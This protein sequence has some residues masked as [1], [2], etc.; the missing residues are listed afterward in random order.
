[1]NFHPRQVGGILCL[2]S[3]TI[4][5]SLLYSCAAKA[6][7]VE[8]AAASQAIALAGGGGGSGGNNP[9]FVATTPDAI[10]PSQSGGATYSCVVPR[11][12]RSVSV[13]F[14]AFSSGEFDLDR[15]CLAL[16]LTE[17]NIGLAYAHAELEGVGGETAARLAK[18]GALIDVATLAFESGI[19]AWAT[20]WPEAWRP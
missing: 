17:A 14:I 18:A 7:V 15:Y 8:A 6:Q 11:G 1:M 19:D 16:T 3:A 12:S 9:Q 13:A 5:V 20:E 2:T 4:V 10:A